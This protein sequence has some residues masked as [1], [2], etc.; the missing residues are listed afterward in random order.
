MKRYYEVNQHN[1]TVCGYPGRLYDWSKFD[2]NRETRHDFGDSRYSATSEYVP[3]KDKGQLIGILRAPKV[4]VDGVPVFPGCQYLHVPY[5]FAEDATI[6]RVRP[7][8][9]MYP[10]KVYRGKLI[11]CQTAVKRHGIW[12]WC[13]EFDV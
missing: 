12:Y 7:N 6:Y 13:L 3:D 11:K 8:D 5:D 2:W 10:G 9:S 1:S 4:V